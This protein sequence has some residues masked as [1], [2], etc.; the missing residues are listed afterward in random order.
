M[1]LHVRRDYFKQATN[2]YVIS[3]SYRSTDFQDSLILWLHPSYLMV[4]NI[5]IPILE[6]VPFVCLYF[7][8]NL[9]NIWIMAIYA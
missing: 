6:A 1:K 5:T 3:A 2:Q 9:Y 8:D 4:I 7:K